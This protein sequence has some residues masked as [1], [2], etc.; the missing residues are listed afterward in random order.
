MLYCC[1]F[2]QSLI[3]GYSLLDLQKDFGHSGFFVELYWEIFKLFQN[4]SVNSFIS[5]RV[6]NC[7]KILPSVHA[8]LK[9][10]LQK[11]NFYQVVKTHV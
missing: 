7:R 9:T 5:I 2:G 6:R 1:V 4:V 10:I 8:L 11:A 3:V